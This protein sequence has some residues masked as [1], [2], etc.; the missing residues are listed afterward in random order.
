MAL[1]CV[2]QD[3]LTRVLFAGVLISSNI[4]GYMT[5]SSLIAL[6]LSWWQAIV[7]IVVGNILATIFIVLNSLPGAFYH[8]RDLAKLWSR[9]GL[10]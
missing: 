7:A 4:S 1:C 9:V 3:S 2:V 6:G 5:G 10:T 8:S